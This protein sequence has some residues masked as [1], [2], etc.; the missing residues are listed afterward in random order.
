ML[1]QRGL[2][3]HLL[4][5]PAPVS[6]AV[7]EDRFN[8]PQVPMEEDWFTHSSAMASCWCSSF[9]S[10]ETRYYWFVKISFNMHIEITVYKF[11]IWKKI[12]IFEV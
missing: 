9:C 5:L 2:F 3:L 6:K 7:E 10:W 1:W 8:I 12:C 4:S 11:V